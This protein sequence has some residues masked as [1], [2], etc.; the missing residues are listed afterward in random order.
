MKLQALIALTASLT[1]TQPSSASVNSLEG[2]FEFQ[3]NHQGYQLHYSSRSLT[4]SQYGLGWT[5]IKE[6]LSK[7][8]S[9]K[10]TGNLLTKFGDY[11]FKYDKEKNLVLIHS[12]SEKLKIYYDAAADTVSEIIN[13]KNH[14]R[15]QVRYQFFETTSKYKQITQ[16]QSNCSPSYTQEYSFLKTSKGL[17]L[18]R[19]GSLP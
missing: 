3:L 5:L 6:N 9:I 8:L 12:P 15:S 19:Q 1:F 11:S 17:V 13:L 14:C 10:L 16:I 7:K 18:T 4:I 2:S